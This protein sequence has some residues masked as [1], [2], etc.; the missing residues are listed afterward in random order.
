MVVNGN[1]FYVRME[2]WI[3][4]KVGGTNVVAID[5]WRGGK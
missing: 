2:G 3:G 4:T 1:V 5:K